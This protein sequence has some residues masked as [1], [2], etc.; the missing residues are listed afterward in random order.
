VSD[1][2]GF[3]EDAFVFDGQ[4]RTVRLVSRASSTN[5]ANPGVQGNDSSFS[6]LVSA[7]GNFVVFSSRASN[8]VANDTNGVFDVFRRNLS[9]NTTERLVAD[10]SS[11]PND[12]IGS[13]ITPDGLVVSTLTR[14]E[15]LPE[16]PIGFFAFDIYVLDTGPA[17]HLAATNTD[18]PDPVTV[19][20]H[21]HYHVPLRTRC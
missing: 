15:L 21:P 8:L 14:A 2:N 6:P 3:V 16:Q 18:S 11:S 10:T 19:R 1:T 9:T 13:D 5:P 12:V 4:N 20:A 7:D 17:A